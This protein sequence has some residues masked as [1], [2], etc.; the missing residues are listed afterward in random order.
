MKKKDLANTSVL[1]LPLVGVL[2]ID[3][4]TT[5]GPDSALFIGTTEEAEKHFSGMNTIIEPLHITNISEI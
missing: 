3:F 2:K 1:D 5:N 4:I